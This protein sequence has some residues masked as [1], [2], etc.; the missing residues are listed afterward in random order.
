MLFHL[1]TRA[2]YVCCTSNLENIPSHSFGT[3]EY[4]WF[5]NM[6]DPLGNFAEAF[7]ILLFFFFLVVILG[8]L[9]SESFNVFLFIIY[10][11]F[12]SLGK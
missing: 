1:P 8:V 10:L 7:D 5:E 9:R 3:M 2:L 6:E 4:G 11:M 12:C